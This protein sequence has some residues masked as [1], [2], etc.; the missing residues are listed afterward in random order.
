MHKDAI[1]SDCEKFRYSLTRTWDRTLP[2]ACF[3]MLNP[4]TADAAEDD[5]T[6]RKCVGFADRQGFGGF[7]AVNLFAFRTTFPIELKKAGYPIGEENDFH[8]EMAVREQTDAV[9]CAWGSNAR[10]LQRP[11]EVL[12]MIR[13][14]NRKPL[15]LSLLGDGTPAHPCMLGYT[16]TWIEIDTRIRNRVQP[17]QD[18]A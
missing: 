1:L 9:I 14:W 12:Q 5:Q 15:A 8:L 13:S 2:I 17:I 3:V 11:T 4:S 10:K 6:I 7:V 16:D 18:P